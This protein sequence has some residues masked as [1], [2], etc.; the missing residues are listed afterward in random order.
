ME[1]EI[2]KMAG[3]S[4]KQIP[5]NTKKLKII[6]II[7]ARG[8]S[9]GIPKKNI[10]SVAGKPLIAHSIK[11]ALGSKLVARTIVSTDD[12]E[13][14][15]IAKKQGAEIIK[16]P[17]KFAQDNT[18][19]LPVFE[20]AL[21]YL[22][23]NGG[24]VADIIVHLRPTS[25]LKTSQHI[26]EAIEILINNKTADAVKSVCEPIQ[27]PFRMWIIKNKY[28]KPLIKTKIKEQYNCPRQLLPGVYWQ[29][30]H[31]DVIRYNTI[32][33]KHSMTGKKILPYVMDEKFMVD[34]DTMSSVKIAEAIMKK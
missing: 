26:D 4:K 16:R 17:K 11:A 3:I 7:P 9:K 20:H 8:G 29:N 19:D 13:I 21:K 28:L 25:P 10:V 30:G 15:A 24:Y 14:T 12:D 22:K 34:I 33:K 27:N 31:V 23:K 18:P 1:A 2:T 6:A 32:I 5:I